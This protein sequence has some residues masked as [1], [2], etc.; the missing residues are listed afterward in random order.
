MYVVVSWKS[1]DSS[2]IGPYEVFNKASCFDLFVVA[3]KH[4]DFVA[5]E[6][7]LELGAPLGFDTVHCATSFFVPGGRGITPLINHD[8]TLTF[9]Q[10]QGTAGKV[11]YFGLHGFGTP[12]FGWTTRRLSGHHALAGDGVV[13]DVW[14]AMLFPNA[15]SL[16]EI[17][18]LAA[19]LPPASTSVWY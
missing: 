14:R 8:A 3:E 15:S 6:G 13:A 18:S 11:Y 10:K 12:C 19:V 9:L 4:L 2:F 7:G 1:Y 17:E 5:A 16:I